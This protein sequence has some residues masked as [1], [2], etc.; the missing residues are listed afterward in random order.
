MPSPNDLREIGIGIIQQRTCVGLR[1]VPRNML[2]STVQFLNPFGCSDAAT[3]TKSSS[4][5]RLVVSN[6]I[7]DQSFKDFCE[8]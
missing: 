2:H 5:G 3:P 6:D 1:Q 4:H 8:T 7:H